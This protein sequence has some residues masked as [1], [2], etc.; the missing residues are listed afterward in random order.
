[1]PIFTTWPDL[2]PIQTGWRSSTNQGRGLSFRHTGCTTQLI[3]TRF[4]RRSPRCSVITQRARMQQRPS[5]ATASVS[6][7]AA[8]CFVAWV[9]ASREEKRPPPSRQ[10]VTWLSACRWREKR[11]PSSTGQANEVGRKSRASRADA[12][13][14]TARLHCI[15]QQLSSPRRAESI[16]LPYLNIGQLVDA[17]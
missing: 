4:L 11:P 2:V 7:C 17:L 1:L 5:S 8:S 3:R 13:W 6:A 15:R 9:R 16:E 12:P 10:R 14:S